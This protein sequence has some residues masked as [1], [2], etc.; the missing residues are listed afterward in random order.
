MAI[1]RATDLGLE[2]KKV[3]MKHFTIST[4]FVAALLASSITYAGEQTAKLSAL[5]IVYI[6]VITEHCGCGY[7]C[8]FDGRAG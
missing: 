1:H 6:D 4:L 7:I 5:D 2:G 8:G 3:M